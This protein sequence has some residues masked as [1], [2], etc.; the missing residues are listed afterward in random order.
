M[1]LHHTGL[2]TERF[3][4]SDD[5]H[6]AFEICHDPRQDSYAEGTL[7][8]QCPQENAMC[9]DK[10]HTEAQFHAALAY[11]LSTLQTVRIAFALTQLDEFAGFAF[12][13]HFVTYAHRLFKSRT[14]CKTQQNSVFLKCAAARRTRNFELIA[15]PGRSYFGFSTHFAMHSAGT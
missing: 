6:E 3:Q 15:S 14:F 7:N 5:A 4:K 9:E 11:T 2:R 8:E 1:A 13:T 10:V 12:S